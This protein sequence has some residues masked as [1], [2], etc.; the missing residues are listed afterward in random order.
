MEGES[1]SSEE[2]KDQQEADVSSSPKL[3]ITILKANTL[4]YQ[5]NFSRTSSRK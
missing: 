4:K 2:K 1:K 5:V 3:E